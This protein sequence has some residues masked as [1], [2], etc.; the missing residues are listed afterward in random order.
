MCKPASMIVTKKKVYWSENTD[1]HHEIITEFGIKEKDARG[2]INIVP[3][4]ICPIDGNLNTP[5]SKWVFSV[6]YVGYSR[7]LPDWWD[8][9]KYEKEVRAAVKHWKKQKVI[10][11]PCILRQG[12]FYVVASDSATVR[13]YG[14]A[15]VRA[16]D[17]ATVIAYKVFDPQALKSKTAVWID[18][19]AHGN[20]VCH[21]GKQTATK[22]Q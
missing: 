21:I 14:C 20:V 22:G 15:T 18:R 8:N 2:N 6:D 13:A 16:Y 7:D 17:S 3:V 5:I 9:E 19:S 1:S 10:T 4:E 11:K 12:Q